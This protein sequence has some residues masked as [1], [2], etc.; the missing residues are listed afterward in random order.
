MSVSIFGPKAFSIRS[1]M[2]P[3]RSAWPFNRLDSAWRDTPSTL[4]AAVTDRLCASMIS[5]RI[6]SPGCGGL[7]IG[8]ARSFSLVIVLKVE[9]EQFIGLDAERQPPIARGA[10]R[11]A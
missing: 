8:M 6:T 10:G 3:L 9:V 4:A 1:A 5:V 2:S 7:N 11:K